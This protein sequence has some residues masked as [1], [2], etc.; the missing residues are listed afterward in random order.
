ML[1]TQTVGENGVPLS[2]WSTVDVT[3]LL[4]GGDG[5]IFKAP[6]LTG[7]GMIRAADSSGNVAAVSLTLTYQK[8]RS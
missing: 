4:Q 3:Q 2:G 1:Y 5:L 8:K 6:A 7:E